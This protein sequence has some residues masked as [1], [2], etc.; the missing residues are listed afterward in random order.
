MR[1]QKVKEEEKQDEV[2]R[3]LF[4]EKVKEEKKIR[5]K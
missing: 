3:N 1:T 4:K 5:D 2:K